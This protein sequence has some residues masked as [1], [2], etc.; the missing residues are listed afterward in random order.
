[1]EKDPL[2]GGFVDENQ[3]ATGKALDV[4]PEHVLLSSSGRG[5]NGVDA[6]EI[7]HPQDDFG[8]PA[9]PRHV[10]VVNLGS[11]FD[12]KEKLRGR[13]GYLGS[14]GIVVLP[15]GAPREWHLERQGEVRHLH[16]YLDP[17]LLRDVAAGA[18]LDP[19]KAEL[20]E[21]LGVRDR[22]IEHAAMSL[23]SELRSGDLLGCRI[24][25][26][27]LANVLAVSLL[28]RYSSLGY[29]SVRKLEHE[30][31]DGLPEA[32]LRTALAY[33]DDNLA[34]NLSLAEIAREVYIS[35]YHFSRMFKLST[36]L[37]PHQYVIRQ[38]I[39]RAKALLMNT[40]LPVGVVAQEVGFASP[41]H[42]TQQFRRLVGVSPSS[43]RWDLS[44]KSKKPT[45]DRKDSEAGRPADSDTGSML[46]DEPTQGRQQP[47]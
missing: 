31:A 14:G 35:P 32:S 20:V 38:R 3:P 13:E 16:L 9:I 15:A 29:S 4:P 47:T 1:M 34:E 21:T 12:A 18:G 11:P 36:G 10:V 23:L 19:D 45:K 2:E 42:F 41:S 27:S 6:A 17:A 33:V 44:Q 46:S 22:Q 43:F 24:Y 26:E 37:S 5:W 8:T 7:N 30:S 28:R 40:E 25:A 39:E